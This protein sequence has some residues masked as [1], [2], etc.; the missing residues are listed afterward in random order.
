MNVHLKILAA[1]RE[2]YAAQFCKINL[3]T[4][5][6]DLRLLYAIVID[7]LCESIGASKLMN[8]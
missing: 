5:D 3:S 8:N 6:T 1:L 4:K 2:I 7:E